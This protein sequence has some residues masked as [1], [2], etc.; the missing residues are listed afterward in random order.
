MASKNL[1]L[2]DATWNG[3]ES[4][5]FQVSGGGTARYI[6]TSDAT[7]V[8][9]DIALN[10]TAYVNGSLVTGT[11]QGG[12]GGG[13]LKIGVLRPDAVLDTSWTYDK[14][15]H[16]DEGV[17]IPSYTTTAQTLKNSG[18]LVSNKSLDLTSYDYLVTQRWLAA[19]TY[20]S[21]SKGKGRQ[22]YAVGAVCYEVSCVPASSVS[23]SS[24]TSSSYFNAGSV[25]TAASMVVFWSGSS[26]LTLVSSNGYGIVEQATAPTYTANTAGSPTITIASPKFVIR[27]SS[28][29]LSSTYWAYI[30]DIRYQYIIELWKIPRTGTV[31][32]WGDT[33]QMRHAVECAQSASRT[34]T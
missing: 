30:T 26:T 21:T 23:V 4:V 18:T 29:Y 32:G 33:S 24:T 14:L 7:A 10:K 16:A 20:S 2:K 3:V 1:V 15:I 31:Y 6:E 11:N 13:S 8:A 12:G 27:G 28:N 34:L 5:D 17:T 9:A 25:H 22:E 19:P